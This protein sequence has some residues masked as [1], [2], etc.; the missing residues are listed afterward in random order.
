MADVFDKLVTVKT[1]AKR[2]GVTT[3]YIRRLCLRHEIGRIMGR[4]RLLTAEDMSRLKKLLT[5]D[6]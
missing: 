6:G 1:A 5:P 4:D 3:G 2:L